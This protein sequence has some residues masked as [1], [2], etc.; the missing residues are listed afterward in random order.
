MKLF[1][2]DWGTLQHY[3]DRNPPWI[4]LSTSTFQDYEFG[5]LQDASKLL[6]FCIWTL[7]GRSNDGSVPCDLDWIKSQCNVKI[8]QMENLIELVKQGFI[9]DAS[10]TLAECLQDARPETEGETEGEVKTDKLSKDNYDDFFENVSPVKAPT[11][12]AIKLAKP[13]GVLDQTWVDWQALRKKQKGTICQTTING[14]MREAAKANIS[15]EEVLSTIVVNNWKGF[16]ASYATSNQN[17]PTNQPKPRSYQNARD[18]EHQKNLDIV[19]RAR[20]EAE[21][22]RLEQSRQGTF[23]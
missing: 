8:I 20:A 22:E 9:I 17:Q 19:A 12:K 13:D 11:P 3:K 2:K 18:A 4:K 6:A 1:I 23:A 5:R 14:L 15:L 21:Q 16:K 7:A 10:N